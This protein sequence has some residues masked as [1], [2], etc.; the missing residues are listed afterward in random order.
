MTTLRGRVVYERKLHPFRQT[1]INRIARAIFW[2]IGPSATIITRLL[3]ELSVYFLRL[4]LDLFGQGNWT[5]IAYNWI[6]SLVD[7]FVRRLIEYEGRET[8]E[9]WVQ[10]LQLLLV[11]YFP[12]EYVAPPVEP[13]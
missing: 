10:G 9:S 1:D 5:P 8:A 6:Y 13:A 7:E 4:V 11:G 3:Y 12:P 2:H